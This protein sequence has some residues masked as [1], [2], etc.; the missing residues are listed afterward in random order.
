MTAYMES[1]NEMRAVEDYQLQK[2]LEEQRRR[3]KPKR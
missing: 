3:N 2:K 1:H